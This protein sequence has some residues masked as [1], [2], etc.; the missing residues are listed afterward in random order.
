MEADLAKVLVTEEAIATRIE[1]LGRE[2]MATYAHADELT[3]IV[4]INGA[5]PFAADL[6]RA[7]PMPL[8]FDCMRVSS[9]KDDTSPVQRPELIDSLRLNLRD[10]HVLLVDDI[11]DTGHTFVKVV[12]EIERLK[13][14]S[15]R[16]CALLEKTGRRE[17]EAEADFV[18]FSIP[19]E[20]VVG[21]GLD[22]AE[23][24]RNLPMI[25]VLKPASQNPPN[26]Q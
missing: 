11:L 18:G 26:F 3:I 6:I 1:E 19:D 24:Y 23:R 16:F 8:R 21:Y 5:L 15:V 13:P 7:I 20:F 10:R 14:A 17:V 9:Y 22:F 25:G 4:I 2:I 12:E